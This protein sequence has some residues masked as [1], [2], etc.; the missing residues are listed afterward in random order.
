MDTCINV[1]K[2]I[3]SHQSEALEG[4]I[5]FWYLEGLSA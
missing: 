1:V 2:G 3:K 4:D 5:T